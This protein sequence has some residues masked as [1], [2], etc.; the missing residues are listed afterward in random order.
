MK[1]FY[2]LCML[3]ALS[4]AG[5][6][7]VLNG[8]FENWNEVSF[9]HPLSLEEGFTSSNFETILPGGVLTVT[10]ETGFAGSHMR[11]ESALVNDVPTGAYAVWGGLPTGEELIFPGGFTF[12]DQ[13]ATG[14]SCDLRH[15]INPTSPG[16][17]IVQFKFQ[18]LPAGAGNLAPGTY[19]FPISGEQETFAPETFEFNPPIGA[20]VDQCVIAFASNN[21]IDEL[22]E[23]FPGDFLEV[24]NLSFE[25]SD[26]TVPGGDFE[27]WNPVPPVFRPDAWSIA[28]NFYNGIVDR[29]EDAFSGDYALQLNTFLD[30]GNNSIVPTFAFQGFEDLDMPTPTI[31]VPDGFYGYRFNYKFFTQTDDVAQ[32]AV[33]MSE[34]ENAPEE[35]W[36]FWGSELLASENYTEIME[37]LSLVVEAN[38]INY[39]GVVFFSSSNFEVME[40]SVAP[41]GLGG[42]T[43]IVDGFELLAE[44]GPCDF[45]VNINQGEQLILCP[46]ESQTLTL[47]GSFDSYQW[48]REPMFGGDPELLE[49]ESNATLEVDAVNFSVYNVWCEVTLDDCVVESNQI[50]IDSYV[51]VPTVIAS[52]ETAF[53]PGES[54]SLEALGAS[55]TVAWYQN[56]DLMEG[57]SDNPLEVTEAGNYVASIF[58]DVCPNTELSSGIGVTVTELPA[59][60]PEISLD[61]D[62][63]LVGSAG[64]ASYAWFFDGELVGDA[65]SYT[66]TEDGNYTL[67]VADANGC[68]GSIDIDYVNVV[69]V[70]MQV[71]TVFPNPATETLTVSSLNGSYA[72]FD[73]TGRMLEQGTA[74][75]KQIQLNV[76]RLAA[77]SYLLQ[78]DGG[79][80]RFVKR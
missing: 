16:L 34:V 60:E 63:N 26:A 22:A 49:G 45:E 62:G 25:N 64:F 15:N 58:P 55:G 51:F 52:E 35:D 77:G 69:E 31:P 72:I 30:Q 47:D 78:V 36:I 57:V 19:F 79:S 2:T 18:G 23:V 28:P 68:T 9:D 40:R 21:L 7:Q 44:V 10:Q 1:H 61:D 65:A 27:N 43:L 70:A 39:I 75:G 33:I 59:P 20:E 46:E 74:Y 80:V 76:S 32:V 11:L 3:L 24:D 14:L 13:N 73:L 4:L 12:T 67:E 56:G 6:A 42:N 37:D 50:G 17:L 71:P 48:Y 29:S 53:C 66:P 5:S 38:N 41:A 8:G 54:V